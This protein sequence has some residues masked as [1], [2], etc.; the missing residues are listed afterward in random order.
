MQIPL[1]ISVASHTRFH[2]FDLAHQLVRLKQNVRLYTGYPK[3]KIDSGLRALSTTHPIPTLVQFGL[4]RLGFQDKRTRIA[5]FVV[6][7][8]GHWLDRVLAKSDVLD[9]ISGC[10]LEGGRRI[11]QEGGIWVCNRGSSHILFQKTILEEEHARWGAPLPFFSQRGVERELTEYHEADAIAVPSEFA[12]RTFIE[13]GIHPEKIFKVPY[14]VDL[15]LFKPKPKQNSKFRVLF[16]GRFS[17]Q[18]GIGYLFEAMKPLVEARHAELWL[19]GKSDPAA[20]KILARYRDIFTDKGS[21]PRKHLADLYSQGSVLVL[22]SVQEG[23]ALVQAQ[24]MACGVPVIA[25]HNTGA[26][27]LFEDGKEGFIVP[28]RDA[29]AIRER[30]ERLICNPELQ[31][32]MGQAALNRVK[33]MG[34]WDRYGSEVLATYRSLLQKTTD[35]RER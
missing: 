26:E 21:H 25:T 13:Q 3:W 7:D 32:E 9:A 4:R 19:I 35:E 24:A 33:N 23:L 16:V 31:R 11:Q 10:G 28:P 2:M 17:I 8:F 6:T 22:P 1:R 20:N 5:D 34:D 27:D 30:I 29:I 12:K 15:S 18:K 14:G